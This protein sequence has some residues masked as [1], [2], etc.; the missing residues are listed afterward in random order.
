MAKPIKQIRI[1]TV[2]NVVTD[3]L[4]THGAMA[5]AVV[6]FTVFS[7]NIPVHAPG[8]FRQV[9]NT[10]LYEMNELC[11]KLIPNTVHITKNI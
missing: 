3:C 6:V 2:N 11:V 4:M 9:H 1:P 7:W 10:I 5:S 8:K